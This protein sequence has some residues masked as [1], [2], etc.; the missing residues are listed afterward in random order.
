VVF[1]NFVNVKTKPTDDAKEN[2]I[3]PAMD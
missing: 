2:I 3:G 1:N